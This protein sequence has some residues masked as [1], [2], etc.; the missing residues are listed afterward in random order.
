MQLANYNLAATSLM[1]PPGHDMQVPNIAK[2]YINKDTSYFLIPWVDVLMRLHCIMWSVADI[3]DRV[4]AKFCE[5]EVEYD[6]VG[7]GRIEHKQDEKSI[8]VYG[9][10]MVRKVVRAEC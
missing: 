4:A 8:L 6:C 7:G 2:T 5:L 9:Y 3:L 1:R 10:S